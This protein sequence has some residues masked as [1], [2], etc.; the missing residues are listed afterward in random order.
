MSVLIRTARYRRRFDENPVRCI[1][2]GTHLTVVRENGSHDLEIRCGPPGYIGFSLDGY[3]ATLEAALLMAHD[4]LNRARSSLP[5]VSVCSDTK[6]GS[7]IKPGI[8]V[9]GSR[10]T[11]AQPH[12]I[13]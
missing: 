11:T 9:L 12:N 13:C 5:A 4:A 10:P 2:L 3:N 7:R 8:Q 6:H 1:E